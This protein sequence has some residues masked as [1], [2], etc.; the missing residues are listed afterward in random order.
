MLLCVF[1]K[2]PEPARQRKVGSVDRHFILFIDLFGGGQLEEV[3][4][5]AEVL[6]VEPYVPEGHLQLLFVQ[7]LDLLI[8]VWGGRG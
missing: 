6:V 4:V 2:L 1:N 8:Q 7:L 5:A 3:V